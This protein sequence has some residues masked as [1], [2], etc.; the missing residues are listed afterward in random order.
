MEDILNENIDLFATGLSDIPGTN[1]SQHVIN[2]RDA[3]PIRQRSYRYTPETRREIERQ[4]K[5]MWEN[6]IIEPSESFWSSPVV[7]ARKR[8]GEMRFCVDYR[9]LNSVTVQQNWPIP[10]LA[11]VI[12]TLSD[13]SPSIFTVMDLRSGYFQIP[14]HPDSRPKTAFT[15]QGQLWQFRRLPFGL[16]NA[17]ANF[18]AVMSNVFRGI[19]YDYVL[20][21]LDDVIVMSPNFDVHKTHLRSVFDRLR[22]ANLRLHRGKC[23]FALERVTYLGHIISGKGV[24]VDPAKIEVVKKFPRPKN[25]REVRGFVGLCNYYRKFLRRFSFIVAPLNRLLMK[26]VSFDWTDDCEEAFE[27]LKSALATTPVFAQPT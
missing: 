27:K 5:E 26:D 10:T 12:D 8:S 1:L 22:Q 3:A 13:K 21:Y 2:T 9:R 24:E 20:C 11:D 17:P 14:V 25:M 19:L 15:V 23:H 6:D 7:L 4:V 16:C 18:C